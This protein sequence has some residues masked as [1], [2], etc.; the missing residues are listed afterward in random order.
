MNM[1]KISGIVSLMKVT[2]AISAVAELNSISPQHVV[3]RIGARL[4][5]TLNMIFK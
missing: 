3:F 4:C 1:V 2:T 5:L